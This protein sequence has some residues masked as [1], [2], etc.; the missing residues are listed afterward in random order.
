MLEPGEIDVGESNSLAIVE[1]KLGTGIER[2]LFRETEDAIKYILK[3]IDG[4]ASY[5]AFDVMHI[6]LTT[7]GTKNEV[8][9]LLLG[10]MIQERETQKSH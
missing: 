7:D 8:T 6:N 4:G 5:K 9:E 3:E 2:K 1:H 10:F